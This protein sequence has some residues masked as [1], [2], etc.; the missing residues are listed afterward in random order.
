MPYTTTTIKRAE[1][2]LGYGIADTQPSATVREYPVIDGVIYTDLFSGNATIDG[3]VQTSV[4]FNGKQ[5]TDYYNEVNYSSKCS[6]KVSISANWRSDTF[7]TEI[8]PLLDWLEADDPTTVLDSA[9]VASKKIEDF[10]VSYRTSS[11]K[12]ED[13]NNA[14]VDGFG[15][16]I[17]RPL[18]L[19]VSEEQR[20]NERYF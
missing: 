7:M 1:Q 6:D 12:K 10:S 11:E 13:L 19:D 4:R 14:F 3:E 20:H 5:G 15:Y 17:R 9:G 2:V 8:A 16:Y 18:I